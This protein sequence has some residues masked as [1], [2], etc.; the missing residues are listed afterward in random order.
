[1]AARVIVAT[2]GGVVHAFDGQGKTIWKSFASLQLGGIFNRPVLVDVNGD[3]VRDVI[4][5]TEK[6]GL[7]AIDGAR[8]W[9]HE[10][11]NTAG[12]M[13]GSV[14]TSPLVADVNGDGVMD[15]VVATDAG[16]VITVSSQKGKVWQIWE[17]KVPEV[18]YAS[19]ALIDAGKQKFVVIATKGEGIIALAV[20][21]GRVAWHTKIA[22]RFFASPVAADANGDGVP[23]ILAVAEDGTVFALNGLTGDEI[24]T[25]A[26]G[27]TVQASPA[28]FDVDNDGMRDLVV[29]DGSGSIKVIS[30]ARGRVV[31]D[32]PVADSGGFVASPVLG[33]LDK[34]SAGMLEI[35][36]AGASGRI[37]AYSL[38]R[39]AGRGEAV[40]P[41]FLGNDVH[42]VK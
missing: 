11:W 12:M 42:A 3:G 15:F 1:M 19:P 16:Q 21:M 39:R 18:L 35:V 13:R 17:Q 4:V 7:V 22:K 23:D 8:G 26:L 29:L 38:N 34:D 32:I 9:D 6:K 25:L 31:L 14:V 24:W 36:A 33:D 10:L 20:D 37:S 30:A 41:V 28:L 2:S 40:W 5:P 27:V